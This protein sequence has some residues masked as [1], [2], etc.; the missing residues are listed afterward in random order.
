MAVYVCQ[1][2][3]RACTLAQC[4][5]LPIALTLILYTTLRLS[6]SIR[7]FNDIYY[8][9]HYLAV[10]WTARFIVLFK[11]AVGTEILFETANINTIEGVYKNLFFICIFI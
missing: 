5:S 4:A 7:L 11:R 1:T 8:I 3:L 2:A 9:K 10:F 6:L